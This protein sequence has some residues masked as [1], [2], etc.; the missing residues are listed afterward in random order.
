MNIHILKKH[1]G[2][3]IIGAGAIVVFLLDVFFIV[4][5]LI[6]KVSDLRCKVIAV[7]S[8]I[9]YM[10]RQLAMLSAT[11]EK[12]DNLKAG[13]AM[14]EVYFPKEEEVP[15]L[16]GEIST[17]AGKLGVD[18]IAI[19]PVKLKAAADL[20][21]ADERLYNEVPIE[22]SAKGGYHQISQFINK[23]ET[24]TK[25]VEVKDVEI[26]SDSAAPRKHFCRLL[27]STYILKI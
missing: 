3:L 20:L 11:L 4:T 27:V 15:G 7:K 8:D 18:I 16:L 9:S 24:Y 13:R 17:M 21:K 22:I 5:P 26:F 10:D 12:L 25:L 19:K 2:L 6:K 14:Y 23:I 1:K